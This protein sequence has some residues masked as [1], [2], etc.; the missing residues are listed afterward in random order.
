MAEKETTNLGD[1]DVAQVERYWQ[2][3]VAA[4]G[5]EAVPPVVFE[6]FDLVCREPG[7]AR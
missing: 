4:N 5:V 6:R 7:T 1:I 3:F 2:R